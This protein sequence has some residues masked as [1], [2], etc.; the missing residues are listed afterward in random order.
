M[1]RENVWGWG[2][3]APVA[4]GLAIFTVG[5]MLVSLWLSFTSYDV[6]NPARFV[7]LANYKYLLTSD[8]AF[9]ISVR[10][11]LTY[12]AASV[13]L[14]LAS[15][16]AAA[17]LLNLETPLRGAFRVLYYIPSLLPATASGVLWAW[18]FHPTDGAMNKLL[19]TVGVEGPAWTQSPQW[20]LPAIIVMGMWGFGGAMVVFLAGLQDTPRTLH[21]AASLDGAGPVRRFWTV[22]WPALSPTVFFNLTMGLI[23]AMKTFDQAFA[24]GQ[25][26]AGPGGPARATLFYALNLYQ[27]AFGHFHMGLASAMAWMLFAAIALLTAINFRLAKRWVHEENS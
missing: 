14:G 8:P 22:T 23:G 21:E 15:A 7:G 11:T 3:L 2:M 19:A 13:P 10:V 17:M 6:V 5:P 9:W 24:F 4:I 12:A 26:G 1:R 16:L 27:Q 20:A 25:S 18:I